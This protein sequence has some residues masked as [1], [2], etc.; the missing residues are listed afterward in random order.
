VVNELADGSTI[1]YRAQLVVVACGTVNS[2]ALLRSANDQHPNGQAHSSD[3]VGRYRTR[4]NNL[5]M[6]AVPKEPNPTSFQKTMAMND[7]YLGSDDWDYPLGGMLGDLGT[8]APRARPQPLPAQGDADRCDRAPGGH[9]PVRDRPGHLG[10]GPE[11]QDG[12]AMTAIRPAG[13]SPA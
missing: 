12:T 13:A 5:A 8:G 10:T 3:L 7:W 4:Q 2:R 1:T 11:P 9:R 6:K